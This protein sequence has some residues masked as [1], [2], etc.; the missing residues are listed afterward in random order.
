[1][2]I[3]APEV[4]F[5]THSLSPVVVG[6]VSLMSVPHYLSHRRDVHASVRHHLYDVRHRL[7]FVFAF[8]HS[9]RDTNVLFVFINVRRDDFA[10]FYGV[11]LAVRLL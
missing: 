3:R 6:Y 4:T 9:S 2:T 10:R 1:M 8:V 7:V 11:V 5:L